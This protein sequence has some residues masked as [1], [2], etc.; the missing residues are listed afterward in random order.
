MIIPTLFYESKA[1]F[2]VNVIIKQFVVGITS[3]EEKGAELKNLNNPYRIF[4]PL[5]PSN[6][7][8]P[9]TPNNKTPPQTPRMTTLKAV[10]IV[11]PDKE[12]C[13]K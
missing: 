13:I 1:G 4:L 8:Q 12:V 9:L 10:F 3:I 2:R 11:K 5:F 7:P 6:P